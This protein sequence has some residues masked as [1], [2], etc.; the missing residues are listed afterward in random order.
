MDSIRGTAFLKFG[1]LLAERG[2][3]VRDFLA[4]HRI[5]LD[6]IGNFDKQLS[7]K[8]L[9]QIFE[10]SA[11]ALGLP[12]FGLELAKRQGSTLMGPLQHLAHSAPTVGE[13]LVAVIRYMRLY[14]PSIYYRLERRPGQALLHFDNPLPSNSQVPQIIEKSVLQAAVLVSE[15]LGKPFIPRAVTF[16]HE[17]Q[18]D[19][20]GYQ[21]YFGCPV[22]FGQDSNALALPGATLQEA[23]VHHDAT[24]HAIVRFYLETHS[25]GKDGLRGE[26]ERKIQALLPS[27]RCN[28]EQVAQALGLHPRTLQRRLADDGVDFEGHLDRIRRNQAEK[29]LRHTTLGVAQIASELGYRR[30]TSFCRAHQRWFDMTPLE[31]RRLHGDP[32]ISLVASAD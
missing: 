27:Q 10:G 3:S 6:V 4:P 17:P 8:S 32:G 31:H 15:L 19:L 7:Y 20:T 29:M 18:G 9:A 11:H 24:L 22:L 21:R 1:E 26:M 23:C 14:S 5:G 2:A 13:A 30:T 16:R 25:E 12:Q 28:L